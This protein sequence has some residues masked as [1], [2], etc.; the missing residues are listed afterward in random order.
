MDCLYTVFRTPGNRPGA[1]ACLAAGLLPLP[2]QP[3]RFA[4][5]RLI[6]VDVPV[7]VG[8]GTYEFL[9][10][11]RAPQPLSVPSLMP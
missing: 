11:E 3:I 8:S 2:P 10:L 7:E 9:G 1:D 4:F 5:F 6:V